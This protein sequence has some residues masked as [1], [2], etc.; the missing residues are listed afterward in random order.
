MILSS[1][2]SA[3]ETNAFLSLFIFEK[4]VI[5]LSFFIN[6]FVVNNRFFNIFIV[7]LKSSKTMKSWITFLTI[8]TIFF[9]KEK[10]FEYI[11]FLNCAR[12]LLIR[13]NSKDKN[14]IWDDIS[15]R[16]KKKKKK[17]RKSKEFVVCWNQRK[18]N[19]NVSEHQT[20]QNSRIQTQQQNFRK[21]KKKFRKSKKQ[22]W[23]FFLSI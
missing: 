8:L 10:T 13:I 3:K 17:R 22:F 21:R 20:S 9:A 6:S 2:I 15:S 18:K 5:I 11:F 7:F 4:R 12:F 14:A 23:L 19:R 1:A 16:W